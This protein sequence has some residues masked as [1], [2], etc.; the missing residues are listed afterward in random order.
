VGIIETSDLC[1][2]GVDTILGIA[3]ARHNATGNASVSGKA[4]PQQRPSAC[5]LSKFPPILKL[6]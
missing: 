3:M 2:G 6:G 5:I 4:N 1:K